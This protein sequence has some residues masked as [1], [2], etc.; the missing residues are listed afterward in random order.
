MQ[1]V[2][3]QGARALT[4]AEYY[5]PKLMLPPNGSD[6]TGNG[7]YFGPICVCACYIDEEKFTQKLNI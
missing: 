2:V 4:L 7:S 6:E 3:F 1:K 5:K